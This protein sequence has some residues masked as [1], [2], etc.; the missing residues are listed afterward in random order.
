LSYQHLEL[1]NPG[2]HVL[3]VRLNRPKQFNALNQIT[4][5]EL[6]QVLEELEK[7]TDEFLIL[8]GAGRAFCFGVDFAEFENRE[9]LPNLLN[10]FQG[11]VSRLYYCSKITIA[12]L[13]GFATGAGLDLALACDFRIASEKIK[14]AEAYISMG[15]VPDGGGSFFVPR[16]IGTG[17]ALEM[18]LTGEAIS[19]EEALTIGLIHR[20]LPSADL[21]AG[22]M[23]FINQLSLKPAKARQFIKKLVKE[24]AA[25]LHDAL[26]KERE[27]QLICFDDPEHLRLAEEFNAKTQRHKAAKPHHTT[28][29]SQ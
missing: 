26:K 5:Q 27:S 24:P 22:T 14:L 13:N 12:C 23:Q 8:T 21:I 3:Q 7:S 15:L 17:R 1:T 29:N 10:V 4:I 25:N 18:L 9:E 19:A 16:L 2:D 20:I 11:L 6:F 28:S